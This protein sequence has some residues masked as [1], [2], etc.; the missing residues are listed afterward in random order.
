MCVCVCV[1]MCVRKF[2]SV[3]VCVYASVCLYLRVR[4]C[5]CK[6]V[7]V[8]VCACGCRVFASICMCDVSVYLYLLEDIRVLDFQVYQSKNGCDSIIEKQF[9]FGR[10]LLPQVFL[11]KKIEHILRNLSSKKLI[12][13]DI[14]S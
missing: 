10:C 12:A 8:C 13:E 5:V 2:V 11:E 3:S 14:Q 7:Y 6:F 1:C 4:V 9:R